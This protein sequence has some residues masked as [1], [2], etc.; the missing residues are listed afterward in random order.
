MGTPTPNRLQADQLR[1]LRA[2]DRLRTG[3]IREFSDDALARGRV[4]AAVD[5][6]GRHVRVGNRLER[7]NLGLV[8]VVEV[9]KTSRVGKQVRFV[10]VA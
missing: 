2:D 9:S 4:R 8:P 7:G 1:D 10:L 6:L 5:P 3:I